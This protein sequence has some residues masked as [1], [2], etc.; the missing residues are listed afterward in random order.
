MRQQFLQRFRLS[1]ND[2]SARRRCCRWW[3]GGSVMVVGLIAASALT[4]VFSNM[5][6]L[7]LQRLPVPLPDTDN[8]NS[9]SSSTATETNTNHKIDTEPTAYIVLGG[10]LTEQEGNSESDKHSADESS[11]VINQYTRSRLQTVLQHYQQHPLP[12]ILSGVESPW[13]QD[14]LAV[15]GVTNVVSENASMNTCENA[16]FT[17]KR[18]A[19][20]HAYLVTDAYHMRRAQRQFALNG[21]YSIAL[22]A[23]MPEPKSWQDWRVNLRHSRRTI[24]EL[25]AY[26]RDI[27]QPQDNCRHA[28]TVSMQTLMSSRKPQ[29][30]K[31]F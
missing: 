7:I 9:T 28:H 14:W 2:G 1:K 10:G 24:Y 15:Q 30:I 17:A 8:P 11:I 16:R 22:I 29:D 5:G 23:A 25:A 3:L 4:P 20:K 27:I 19:I 31:L 18:L 12:I 21:V 6:L 13:M 26:M